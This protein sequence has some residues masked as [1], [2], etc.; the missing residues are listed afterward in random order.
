MAKLLEIVA[1][2]IKGQKNV[3]L[4]AKNAEVALD[5]MIDDLETEIVVVTA[6]EKKEH[7]KQLATIQ[8]LEAVG[9]DFSDILNP[10][11]SLKKIVAAR[12][13]ASV[14]KSTVSPEP[15]DSSTL[16]NLKRR[17]QAAIELR[18]EFQG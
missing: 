4:A 12:A 9:N 3:E 18:E 6:N 2:V 14:R 17:L 15:E 13:E 7:R 11:E 1:G 5:Q 8:S 16:V 10:T